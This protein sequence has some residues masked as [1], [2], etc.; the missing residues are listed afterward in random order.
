MRGPCLFSILLSQ[1]E[2][3]SCQ[4]EV[5]RHIIGKKAKIGAY[6]QINFFINYCRRREVFLILYC[7]SFQTCGN[8]V[9]MY[10]IVDTDILYSSVP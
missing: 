1:F 2:P 6:L 5:Y 7:I 3:C 9:F 10:F 4:L 8:T